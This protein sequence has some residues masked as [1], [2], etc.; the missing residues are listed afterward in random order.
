MTHVTDVV[1]PMLVLITPL[2]AVVLA[3]ASAIR[4]DH[5]ID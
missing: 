4:L 3:V 1:L 2:G 5:E